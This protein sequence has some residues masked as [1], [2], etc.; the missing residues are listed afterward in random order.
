LNEPDRALVALQALADRFSPGDEP[1]QV[2]HLEGL[3]LTAL[4]RYDD[5]AR[6]LSRAAQRERRSADLMCHLAEAELRAGR[7]AAAQH[8]L[9]QA[10]A[11]DPNHAASRALAA[12]MAMATGA[13]VR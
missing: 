4:G 3:A 5:A 12:Q 13:I 7:A 9:Q 8:V 10:L 2:L 1:Q 6:A 11:L